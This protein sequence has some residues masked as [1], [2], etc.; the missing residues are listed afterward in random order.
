MGC[1]IYMSILGVLLPS[2]LVSYLVGIEFELKYVEF[3]FNMNFIFHIFSHVRLHTRTNQ[4]EF[5]MDFQYI[6]E[7]QIFKLHKGVSNV[8]VTIHVNVS[9][10][11]HVII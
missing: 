9:Y 4:M 2:V 5:T 11:G 1:D 7:N 8:R 3:E 6:N 10:L